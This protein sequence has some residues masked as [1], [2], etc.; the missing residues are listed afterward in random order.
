MGANVTNSPQSPAKLGIESPVPIGWEKQPV[1][2][3]RTLQN[4]QI[5]Q[6][7]IL[8]HA[9]RLLYQWVHADIKVNYV[10]QILFFRKLDKFTRLLGSHCQGLLTDHVFPSQQGSFGVRVMKI[11]GGCQMNDINVRIR[12][13]FLEG[14]I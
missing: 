10:D 1:L 14:S 4:E 13:H 12:Q 6:F 3:I 2:Q 9:T 5:A 11:I 7:S 8:H